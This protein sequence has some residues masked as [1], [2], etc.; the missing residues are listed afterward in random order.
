MHVVLGVVD[1]ILLLC[2]LEYL[3]HPSY[4]V[5]SE[6]AFFV[7]HRTLGAEMPSVSD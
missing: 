4:V 2:Y 1:K 5:C 3:H 6:C 7:L